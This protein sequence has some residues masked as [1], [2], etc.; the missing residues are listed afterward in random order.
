[1]MFVCN[2]LFP[3]F[4]RSDFYFAVNLSPV[5]FSLTLLSQKGNLSCS[6]V[7]RKSTI[8]TRTHNKETNTGYYKK[9]NCH[10][11]LVIRFKYIYRYVQLKLSR[12]INEEC[13]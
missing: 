5:Q 13:Q 1:M 6:Q 8:Y 2:I 7:H 12:Y 3:E 9:K 4:F 11:Y 10:T